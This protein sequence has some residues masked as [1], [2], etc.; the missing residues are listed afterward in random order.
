MVT[1][2]TVSIAPI[3]ENKIWQGRRFK[4]REYEAWRT[5]IGWLLR[6]KQVET[7]KGW[8][9]VEVDFYIKSFVATDA[10]NLEKGFFDSLTDAG[11]IEDDKWIKWHRAEKW[12]VEDK[13][14]ERISFRI[15]PLDFQSPKRAKSKRSLTPKAI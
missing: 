4:T 3:S 9:A 11:L 2:I 10:S 15:I 14:E 8:V 7:V 1:P 5:H 12:P 6:R 13:S